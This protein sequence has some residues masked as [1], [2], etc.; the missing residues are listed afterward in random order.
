MAAAKELAIP[1]VHTMH[2]TARV[3]NLN[4][5]EGESPEPM[6]RVQGETQVVQAA[7]ALIAND[8]YIKENKDVLVKIYQG[9]MKGSVEINESEIS[10]QEGARILEK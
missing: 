1:L 10:K 3:K 2:T 7:D 6:I 8:S 4:L 9:W 5:A